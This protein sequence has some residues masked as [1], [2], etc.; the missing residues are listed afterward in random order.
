MSICT[1]LLSVCTFLLFLLFLHPAAKGTYHICGKYGLSY[2]GGISALG[3]LRLEVETRI[4][5]PSFP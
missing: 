4:Q 5:C 2:V 3:L 1:F